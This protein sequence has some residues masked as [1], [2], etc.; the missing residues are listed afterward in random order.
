MDRD[1]ELFDRTAHHIV[2][3]HLLPSFLIFYPI[4]GV[5]YTNSFLISL[6]I[7]PLKILI[8]LLIDEILMQFESN[9]SLALQSSSFVVRFL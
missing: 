6:K 9:L 2:F 4:N 7:T 1:I 5:F 8:K 3:S